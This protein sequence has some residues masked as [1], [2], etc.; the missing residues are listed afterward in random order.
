MCKLHL[1]SVLSC[2]RPTSPPSQ[3]F[4]K[5]I[6]GL[7]RTNSMPIADNNA[8]GP[9]SI[10]MAGLFGHNSASKLGEG[11]LV[12]G[13]GDNCLHCWCYSIQ[14]M[15]TLPPLQCCLMDYIGRIF[16]SIK[17]GKGRRDTF[18]YHLFSFC[19]IA[20][21]RNVLPLS[22]CSRQQGFWQGFSV[23]MVFLFWPDFTWG[24]FTLWRVD[25]HF[26]VI[27]PHSPSSSYFFLGVNIYSV[28]CKLIDLQNYKWKMN[29]IS[30]GFIN[31]LGFFT[32]FSQPFHL[33][34][35]EDRPGCSNSWCGGSSFS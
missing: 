34:D 25:W 23:S 7:N 8:E 31:V 29:K 32:R 10:D 4:F 16:I 15:L 5:G 26:S 19:F 22:L 9:L 11:W 20:F 18:T 3:P 6:C 13:E 30:M 1:S 17:R 28:Q 21:E 24:L 33:A 35:W 2:H 14:A 27:S 12:W